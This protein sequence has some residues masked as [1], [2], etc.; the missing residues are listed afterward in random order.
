MYSK[1]LTFSKK[2]YSEHLDV[3]DLQL[4]R[5][6]PKRLNIV[7]KKSVVLNYG[8]SNTNGPQD[9]VQHSYFVCVRWGNWYERL[10]G[11]ASKLNC[12]SLNLTP[13]CY[14]QDM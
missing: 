4:S 8:D 7:V 13:L 9:P 3:S 14:Y 12:P 1:P 5:A 6:E 10:A 11:N 2:F